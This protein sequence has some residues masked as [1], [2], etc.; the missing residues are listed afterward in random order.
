MVRRTAD[1]LGRRGLLIVI[2]DFYDDEDRVATELHRA[3][4][5]GHDVV[6]FQVLT[7][8]E[9]TLPYTR[10]VEFADL[11]SGARL[12]VDAAMVRREYRDAV[13]EFLERMRT[14]ALAEGRQHMLVVTDMPPQ[15]VL[16]SFL[17]SRRG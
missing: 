14:R 11:E 2:S 3:Q 13:A 7:R 9:I 16:R 6:Q 12:P 5:M 4:R 17:L 1:R 15:R 10:A 8:D